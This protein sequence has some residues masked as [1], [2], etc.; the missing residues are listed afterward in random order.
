MDDHKP[1]QRY[2][3]DVTDCGLLRES[4]NTIKYLYNP[5]H[6]FICSVEI[7]RA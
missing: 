2:G 1:W 4:E 5:I 3:K 7:K 6:I